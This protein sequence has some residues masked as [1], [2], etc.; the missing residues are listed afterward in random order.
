MQ[1]SNVEKPQ[2]PWSRAANF[3]NVSET[4]TY[5]INLVVIGLLK[6]NVFLKH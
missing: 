5:W 4:E 3:F 2:K 1:S 6:A